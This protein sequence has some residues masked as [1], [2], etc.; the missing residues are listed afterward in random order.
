MVAADLQ[1]E[2]RDVDQVG[3]EELPKALN[4]HEVAVALP[5]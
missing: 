1:Q 2:E 5:E 3:E 4:E